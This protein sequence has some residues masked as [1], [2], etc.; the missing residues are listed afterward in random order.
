MKLENLNSNSKTNEQEF[1]ELNQEIED[2]Y[3]KLEDKQSYLLRSR[4]WEYSCNNTMSIWFWQKVVD[5]VL[6]R[7]K[8]E[9]A[10]IMELE[11]CNND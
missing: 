5:G 9:T 7:V 8:K 6:Y 11:I 4:G 2:E 1:I 10:F 3:S